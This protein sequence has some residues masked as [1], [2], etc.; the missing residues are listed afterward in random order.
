MVEL[1]FV[2]FGFIIGFATILIYS[3]VSEASNTKWYSF[4]KQY[5]PNDVLLR[6]M[7]DHI[8][9]NGSEIDYKIAECWIIREGVP[10]FVEGISTNGEIYERLIAVG[11]CKNLRWA[12]WK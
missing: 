10:Y 9:L 12:L 7:G 5:P 4:E 2:I 11:R 1:F 6:V 8:E 3:H